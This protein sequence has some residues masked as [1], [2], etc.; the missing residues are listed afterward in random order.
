MDRM[1]ASLPRMLS[2]RILLLRRKH[3]GHVYICMKP[4][5]PFPELINKGQRRAWGQGGGGVSDCQ[6]GMALRSGAPTLKLHLLE[7]VFS[8]NCNPGFP[9]TC[10][11]PVHAQ[12]RCIN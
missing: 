10:P 8:P 2:H 1:A 3:H 9:I 11:L 7:A 12:L 6:P 4:C 5:S